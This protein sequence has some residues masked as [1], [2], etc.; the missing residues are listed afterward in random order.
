MHKPTPLNQD[1]QRKQPTHFPQSVLDTS[2][3]LVSW[4]GGGHRGGAVIAPPAATLPKWQ[5]QLFAP[6]TKLE[7]LYPF[8][9]GGAEMCN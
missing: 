9:L 7:G 1:A 8:T 2:E 6:A 4:D 5:G 3:M